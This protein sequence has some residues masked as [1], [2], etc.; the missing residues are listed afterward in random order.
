MLSVDLG[1]Q[2][3]TGL[4]QLLGLNALPTRRSK[5][6]PLLQHTG[7]QFTGDNWVLLEHPRPLHWLVLEEPQCHLDFCWPT[8]AEAPHGIH[9]WVQASSSWEVAGRDRDPCRKVLVPRN[10]AHPVSPQ[11]NHQS[12]LIPHNAQ[13]FKSTLDQT[14]GP[15]VSEPTSPISS[16]WT[17]EVL[18]E[19]PGALGLCSLNS[20]CR[21]QL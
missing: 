12:T 20:T 2:R 8:G 13:S 1:F 3:K 18:P 11:E 21:W 15:V 17:W 4:S 9:A 7:W 14:S 10:K 5:H 6:R 19:D 16:Q